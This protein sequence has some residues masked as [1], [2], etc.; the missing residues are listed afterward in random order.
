MNKRVVT[1][2]KAAVGIS[3]IAFLVYKIGAQDVFNIVRS[4][5]PLA[6]LIIAIGYLLNALLN[7]ASFY[8]ILS[9]IKVSARYSGIFFSFIKSWGIGSVLPGK[10]GDLSVVYFLKKEGINAKDSSAMY[11]IDKMV[12]LLFFLII[13]MITAKL[14]LPLN[15]FYL[16]A[17]F[18]LFAVVG[19]LL[20]L[21]FG[22]SLIRKVFGRYANYIEAFHDNIQIVIKKPLLLL[23]LFIISCLRW[24]VL[25]FSMWILLSMANEHVSFAYVFLFSV[26]AN[27]L[28]LLPVTVSGIGLKEAAFVYL[29]AL[30][31]ATTSIVLAVSIVYSFVT[32]VLALIAVLF[33]WEEVISARHK[34]QASV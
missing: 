29:Y 1:V 18:L 32:I 31:G 15:A 14:F 5:S 13:A 9:S 7:S 33:V 25:S 2:V 30:V 28:A 24:A 34:K 23:I 8:L 11:V 20:F 27:I 17:C 10:V 26:T 4:T 3:I 21:K 19:F 6:F 16:L 22:K 12:V